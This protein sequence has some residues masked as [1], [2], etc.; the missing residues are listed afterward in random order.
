[1]NRRLLILD[2]ESGLLDAYRIILEP[3]ANSSPMG[4]LVSSRS[5]GS[6][7]AVAS[8]APSAETE[9]EIFEP[10]YVSTGE[11]AIAA[12]Q[13]AVQDEQPFVGGFFDVKLGPGIDGIETIRQ[14]KDIDPNML[15]V[16]VTAYQDRNVDE[17]FKI[18]GKEFADRWDFMSKPFSRN[19]I[20]QKARNLVA[21]WDRKKREKEYLHQIQAQQA[22]LI[23]TERLAAVGTLARGIGHE[24]GN[25]L[26]GIIGK[27]DLARQKATPEAMTEALK[28][29][30]NSAERA[31][32][33]TRNLQTLVKVE[34]K[35][36]S[37]DIRLIIKEC[38]QLVEHELRKGQIEVEESFA[39]IKPVNVSKVEI[40]QVF[41]NLTLNAVHA[42]A[43][44]PGKI[45]VAIEEVQEGVQIDFSDSG[46]GI[47]KETLTK[48]FQPLFTTKGDKGSGIGLS[49]T[50]KIIDNHQGRISVK[51]QE[52]K[53]TT[54]R[55]WLPYRAP[56]S[57]P[58]KVVS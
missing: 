49:V 3:G 4:A 39:Q 9:V 38:F 2:D 7:A 45:R 47:S 53:G 17:I 50:K 56:A 34:G 23:K 1:M 52:G 40:G 12:I 20:V 43:G 6:A 22:Q 33:I 15:F 44:K 19:E 26:L 27:A 58:L 42:M 18:F 10:V 8:S 13:K 46:C 51:S 54:F 5:G 57:P 37:A 24:F 25:I 14:V 32:V 21:N 55:M 16:T 29:I 35:R 11:E 30:S 36:E 31:G 41:L 48:I 28:V